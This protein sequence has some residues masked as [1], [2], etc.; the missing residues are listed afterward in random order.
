[1]QIPESPRRHRPS[2]L[3]ACPAPAYVCVKRMVVRRETLPAMPTIMEKMKEAS[4]FTKMSKAKEAKAQSQA[5][6]KVQ[7]Q[8]R[9]K[10][11]RKSVADLKTEN[12]WCKCFK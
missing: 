8:V 5:A 1:M 4:P 7:A 2:L 11:A 9:G 3:R 10:N 6:T 12:R